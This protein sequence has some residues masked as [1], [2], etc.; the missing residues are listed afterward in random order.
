MAPPLCYDV[1]DDVDDVDDT[2][3]SVHFIE[4]RCMNTPYTIC[5]TLYTEHCI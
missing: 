2:V 5:C 3:Y 1:S 4:I